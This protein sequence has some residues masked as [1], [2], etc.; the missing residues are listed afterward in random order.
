M[1]TRGKTGCINFKTGFDIHILLYIKQITN[2]DLEYSTGNSTQ[3]SVMVY[4]GKGSKK[5]CVYVYEWCMCM[6]MCVLVQLL[7]RV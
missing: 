2:N 7:S 3:Y 6:Y 5:E 1:V 4:M